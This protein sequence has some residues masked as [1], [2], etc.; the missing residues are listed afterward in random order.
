M[1]LISWIKQKAQVISALFVCPNT[2]SF[3]RLLYNQKVLI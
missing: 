1:I 3:N 2:R